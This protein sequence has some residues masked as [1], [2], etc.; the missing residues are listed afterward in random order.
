MSDGG[1]TVPRITKAEHIGPADTGDNIEAKRVA[2]YQ[3]NGSTW[4]RVATSLIDSPYDYVGFTNAD[5]NG[6]YQ[7]LTF[8]SGGSGGTTARTLSLTF[9]GS[10]NVTSITRT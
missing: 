4:Q 1:N 9:D 8:K 7:T 3:W 6:N 10:N 2:P 5:S